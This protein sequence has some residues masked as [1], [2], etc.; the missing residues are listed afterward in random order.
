MQ[1]DPAEQARRLVDERFP[2]ALAVVLAGSTATGRA[3]PGSDLDIAVLIEDGGVT[4]RETIRF[5][6]R[7]VELFVHTRAGLAALFA[8]DVAA[9]RAVMQS[10]YV[11]GL[12]LVDR[13]GEARHVRRLAEADLREG[14][15]PLAPGAVETR[16]YG[17]TDALDDLADTSDT[18]ER[19]AVA[20]LVVNS[21]ADLLCDHHQAW[22]GSGKWLPRRLM[23]A[24]ARRGA[25]L[26]RGHL[27]SCEAGDPTALFEAA[28]EILGLVGGPL[29]EGYR[30]TWPG[31]T[32][33]VAAAA[34]R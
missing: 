28:S 29:R 14:P 4:R 18:I 16:R 19:L 8:A 7:V 26:L 11:S 31:G 32:D 12:V 15:P 20:G 13:N 23:E 30:R 21:A 2:D 27:H 24:D 3:T 17:L 22:L 5:E 25:A 1:A 33:S 6:G 34:G 9:R 10:M